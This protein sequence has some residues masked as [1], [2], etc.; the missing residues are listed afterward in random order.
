[1]KLWFFNNNSLLQC[2]MDICFISLVLYN[3]S[4]INSIIYIFKFSSGTSLVKLVFIFWCT[5][6]CKYLTF[7]LWKII[8]S[9]RNNFDVRLFDVIVVRFS[10]YVD[11]EIYRFYGSCTRTNAFVLTENKEKLMIRWKWIISCYMDSA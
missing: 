4:L 2:T 10:Q 7:T 6:S 1:M 9:I 5:N 8:V 3:I 11:L